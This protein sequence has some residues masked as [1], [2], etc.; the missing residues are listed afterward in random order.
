MS[1]LRYFCVFAYSGVQHILRV[2]FCFFVVVFFCL[3]LMSPM[4]PFSLDCSFLIASSMFSIMPRIIACFF[5][6]LLVDFKYTY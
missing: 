5:S 6:F 4:L 1:Y 2:L 3:R